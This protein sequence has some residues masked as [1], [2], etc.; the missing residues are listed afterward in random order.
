MAEANARPRFAYY[1]IRGAIYAAINR[2]IF[3]YKGIDFEDVKHT[4]E[5]WQ[6]EKPNLGL[7]FPNLPYLID[8]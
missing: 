2:H 8:E 7:E 3:H 1:D 6:A 5:S 4:R